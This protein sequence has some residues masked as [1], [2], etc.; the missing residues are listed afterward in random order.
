MADRLTRY[1][2]RK[3]LLGLLLFAFSCDIPPA[4]IIGGEGSAEKCARPYGRESIWTFFTGPEAYPK[5][6]VVQKEKKTKSR[7]KNQQRE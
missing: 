6:F 2:S 3:S 5:H 1:W 4:L 7:A